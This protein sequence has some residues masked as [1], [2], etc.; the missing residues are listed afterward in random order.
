MRND[1]IDIHFVSYATFFDGLLSNGKK[2]KKIY[3]N[4]L[5]LLKHFNVTVTGAF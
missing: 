1:I 5:F 2:M 4:V 3:S